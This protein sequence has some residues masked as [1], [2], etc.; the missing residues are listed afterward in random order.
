MKILHTADLHL[1]QVIY[2]N[3][4][5]SDEHRH[6]FRQLERWCVEEGPDAL[7]VSGDV[8][9]IQQPSAAVK[10]AFTD[11]FVRL[12]QVCPEMHIVIIAG[13]HDSA[14][15][16]EA[17]SA[18]WELAN[19]HLVGNGPTPKQWTMDNGQWTMDNGQLEMDNW[20]W[21]M[22]NG[23]WIIRIESG[24]IVALPYMTGERREIIQS[25]LDKVADDNTM[26]LPVVMMAHQAVRGLDPAGHSFD[27]GTL[28]TLERS[29]MGCGYDYLA[30]GHIHK[31]QTIYI[32]LDFFQFGEKYQTAANNFNQRRIDAAAHK[33]TRCFWQIKDTTETVG[34]IPKV[35]DDSRK[36]PHVPMY[37][38]GYDYEHGEGTQSAITPEQYYGVFNLYNR[39]VYPQWAPTENAYALL[40]DIK[41]EADAAGVKAVFFF[42]PFNVDVQSI[43]Y[44][45]NLHDE[46]K[47]VKRRVASITPFYDFAFVSPITAARQNCYRDPNHYLKPVGDKVKAALAAGGDSDIS[48]FVNADNIENILQK[49]NEAYKK[50]RGENDAYAAALDGYIKS[51]DELP[52]GEFKQ[53][54]GF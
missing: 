2:Q 21:T 9:D 54:W 31:P 3:Y 11:Y 17:D 46:F 38:L 22:E 45:T 39:E 18:V 49:E 41:N 26:G 30:L 34:S 43:I 47:T 24:Y 19:V 32:G 48:F 23:K 35:I 25:I 1:G 51:K 44:N 13:N 15:R 4:D 33:L 40:E 29:A 42:N 8:F 10:R 28:R 12:H 20:K 16:I 6:F 53:Y 7:L 50:W 37:Y 5:R 52:K 36:K 14:S 27:I